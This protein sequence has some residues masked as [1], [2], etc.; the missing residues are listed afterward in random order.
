[1]YYNPDFVGYP[2]F[3]FEEYEE[4]VLLTEE[5]QR[6]WAE[7]VAKSARFDWEEKKDFKDLL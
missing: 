6:E 2:G 5:Y 4:E 1:M 3:D 7:F